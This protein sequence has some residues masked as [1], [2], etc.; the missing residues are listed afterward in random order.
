MSEANTM[1]EKQILPTE[2]QKGEPKKQK[3]RSPNYPYTGLEDA[4]TRTRELIAIAGIHPVRV[5]TAREVWGYQKGTGNQVVAALDAYGLITV[6]GIADER[7]LK[8]TTEARK[9]LDNTSDCPELLKNAALSPEIH[10]E[11]WTYYQ[12]HLPP[13]N[14]VVREYLV[15]Q[16]GFN[17]AYV[18]KF[19]DQLRETLAFANVVASDRID[20]NVE[21]RKAE[22]GGQKMQPVQQTERIVTPPPAN[23]AEFEPLR[24]NEDVLSFNL[25]RNGRAQVRFNGQVTQEAI[26]KLIALLELSVDTY[27]TQ[28]EL[29]QPKRAMWRNKDHDRPVTVTGELGKKDGKKFYSIEESSTGIPEDEMEFEE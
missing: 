27:P 5:T 8:I 13:D 26:R 18:D 15:Y 29:I 20:A 17:P 14:R 28:A 22:T 12:G 4:L 7:N 23:M 24:L 1:S 19:I 25:S 2:S 10:K 21:T 9:I 11:V 6:E 16:K 3:H